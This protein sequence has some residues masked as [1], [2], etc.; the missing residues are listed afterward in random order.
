MIELIPEGGRKPVL[1]HDALRME[2]NDAK[3]GKALRV[4]ARAL[5]EK[6]GSGDVQAIRELA[7]RL[8]G[9]VPQA[10]TG[11]D[12]GNLVVQIVKFADVA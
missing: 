3:D 10:V 7:D 6:A 4:I 9:K 5:L 2:I 12:G 11:E 8:D 1:F